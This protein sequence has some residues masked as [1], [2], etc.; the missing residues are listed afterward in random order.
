MWAK[1]FSLSVESKFA[2][3]LV[4]FYFGWNIMNIV[5][6]INKSLVSLS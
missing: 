5:K 6:S 3:A 4:L 2:F 1:G